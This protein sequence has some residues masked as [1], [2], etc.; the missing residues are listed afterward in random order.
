MPGL[1]GAKVIVTGGA[2]GYG[3]GIAKALRARGANVWITGRDEV[4]LRAAASAMNVASIAADVT[5]G[6]D[7]DRVFTEVTRDG[8]KL[9]VL[10]NNA[11]AGIR[12]APL[13]EQE[14]HEVRQS[15]EVNLVGKALGCRRAA[16]MMTQQGSGT[17]INISSVCARKS[18][19]GWSVYSAAKA[20]VVHMTR[21][22]DMEL[23]PHGV[24]ATTI[25]PSWG[26]T[27]FTEAAGLGPR[28]TEV[29][30]QCIKSEELG[31]LV[32]YICEL[33]PHLIVQDVTVWPMVQE[34]DS[35]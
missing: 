21:C 8:A 29:A 11:G 22:L 28:D 14:D 34:L 20:G 1:D 7:W 5:Q 9:D 10:I 15:V 3:A 33:P 4:Q 18:W 24:R 23:R 32:A 27:N 2:R 31:D 26:D 6:E 16:K 13:D 25:I 30:D 19:P 12:I 17:I 35:L